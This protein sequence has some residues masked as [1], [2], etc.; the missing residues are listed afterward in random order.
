MR[1]VLQHAVLLALAS[2]ILSSCKG[3]LGE[4]NPPGPPWII[5]TEANSPLAGNTI[6]A[7]MVDRGGRVWFATDS[8]ASYFSPRTKSWGLVRDSIGFTIFNGSKIYSVTSIAEGKDRSIWFGMRGGGV[9]RYNEHSENGK[10]WSRYRSEIASDYVASVASDVT[11]VNPY[12]E[13]W[14]TSVIG[15]S[16]WHQTD[17]DNGTWQDM[18]SLIPVNHALSSTTSPFDGRVWIGGNSGNAIEL[19]YDTGLKWNVYNDPTMVSRINGIA[20]DGARQVWFAKQTGITSV[21]IVT[22]NLQHP[23]IPGIGSLPAGEIHAVETDL[24]TRR[25]FGTD[26]GLIGLSDTVW[27]R[28][29]AST[30]PLPHNTVTAV[31]YDRN[32]NLWIGT[33]NGAAAYNPGGTRF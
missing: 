2:L 14:I 10:I 18:T 4:P 16:R 13:V 17:A 28:M 29:T 27:S 9:V 5:Y 20:I 1:Y 32:G 30:S 25:W 26:S 12:G 23:V 11:E 6:N 31:R 21:N 8:G 33:K 15:V 22:G 7:I 24:R 3:D 19:Y